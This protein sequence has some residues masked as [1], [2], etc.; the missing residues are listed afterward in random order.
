MKTV[1]RYMNFGRPEN[2]AFRSDIEPVLCVEQGE[3]FAVETEDTYNG[4]LR[5][6]PGR[7]QPRDMKPYTDHVPYWYNPICGPVYVNG[8]EKGD[9]LAVRIVAIDNM[10]SGTVATV[11]RAHHFAGLRG[12]E[13]TDEPYTGII[14][15]AEAST[16][17]YG[18]RTH[19]WK[20]RPFIGT[21]AAA[22]EFEVLSPLTTSFGSTLASG[23]N[24]D[25]CAVAPGATVYLQSL[26]EGGLVF[27]GDVHASQGDGEVCGVANEVAATVT[28]ECSVIKNKRLRNVRI[29]NAEALIS[30]Y[31]YRPIED[32]FRQAVRDLILWLEED[33]GLSRREAYLLMSVCPD[34]RLRTYQ[35]CA[36]L[37]RLE[38]TVG[39][40]FPRYL[41]T[42]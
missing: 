12:W 2:Y 14:A 41:L 39:A 38:I 24:L 21:L 15:N 17:D 40:Q 26:N 32:A 18:S 36:G 22:P 42:G 25:C 28:L 8:A 6:D 31:C 11:P 1:P 9:V 19:S 16:W 35:M 23:G 7:V 37:G 29:T 3:T 34:F 4:V 13:E 10:S 27:L 33:Y 30:V 20:P 5:E